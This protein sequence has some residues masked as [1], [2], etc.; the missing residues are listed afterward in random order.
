MRK[1]LYILTALIL[2]VGF[3]TL[4]AAPI[5]A[6]D[7]DLKLEIIK[8]NDLDRSHADEGEPRLPG[9]RF[10]VEGPWAGGKDIYDDPINSIE[11]ITD[12]SGT[13]ILGISPD[14]IGDPP[15]E[16]TYVITEFPRADCVNTDPEDG[17]MKKTAT[18]VLNPPPGSDIDELS[19][20]FGNYCTSNGNGDHENGGGTVGGTVGNIDKFNIVAP[21]LSVGLIII[22][23]IGWLA[24]RRLKT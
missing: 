17:T 9:W 23:G 4:T 24:I 19:V 7:F 1:I 13:F 2:M 20:S 10:L 21:W 11:V 15:W 5:E 3:V 14:L 12:S 18:F 6:G 16:F 8:Y 22:G